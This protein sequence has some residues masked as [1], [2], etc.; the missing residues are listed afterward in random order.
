MPDLHITATGSTP[1]IIAN[2]AAGLVRMVGDAY[3]ENAF[4]LF[5]PVIE[6][7]GQYL[8]Q[9]PM[10]ALAVELELVYLNTSSIRAMMDIFDSL[11]DAHERGVQV[12]VDWYFDTGNGRVGDLAREFRE[13]YSFPF[14]VIGRE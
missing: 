4:E 5:R 6:W 9:K 10:R 7:I 11:E 13:D 12:G 1:E 2:H 8:T 3:P 14:R